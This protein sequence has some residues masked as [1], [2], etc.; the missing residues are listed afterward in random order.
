MEDKDFEQGSISIEKHKEIGY[1]KLVFRNNVKNVL[2]DGFIMQKLTKYANLNKR[3]DLLSIIAYIPESPEETEEA[4]EKTE[5]EEKKNEEPPKEGEQENKTPNF[6][7]KNCK[8][9]FTSNEECSAFKEE[10]DKILVK[11]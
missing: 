9:K 2:F 8:M 6:K 11:E 7:P 5:V 1:Y 4:K 10:L 3:N